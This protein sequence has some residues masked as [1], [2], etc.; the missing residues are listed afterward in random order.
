MTEALSIKIK[1]Q[2]LTLSNYIDTE[3]CNTSWRMNL[4]HLFDENKTKNDDV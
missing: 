2:T 3:S 1:R 4:A